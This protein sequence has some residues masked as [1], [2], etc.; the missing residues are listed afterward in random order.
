MKRKLLVF[1][2]AAV[3]G[4]L[5]VS[6]YSSGP[7]RAAT[8]NR[9]GSGST[10]AN[11]S[12]GGCHAG[13]SAATTVIIRVTNSSGANVTSWEPGA[14]YTVHIDGANT[15]G[16]S[17]FGF[18]S[19]AV[20]ATATGT[21]AGTFSATGDVGV[22]TG[23]TP[24]IIEHNRS[25]PGTVSGGAATY[26]AVYTWVAPAAGAGTVRFLA[27]LNAVNGDNST[28][29]D[30]PAA[31]TPLDLPEAS[32]TNVP[33]V[34][35]SQISVYPNPAGPSLHLRLPESFVTGAYTIRDVRGG[36]VRNGTLQAQ[37]GTAEIDV[38][39]LAGGAYFVQVRS[40]NAT[41]VAPFVKR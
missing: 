5:V 7:Y 2:I 37:Q 27:T 26:R 20:R 31:A 15:A 18:Q 12:G 3:L 28:S 29:G 1:P 36:I 8:L 40:G 41:L 6:S 19:T 39:T 9:T 33:G 24:N 23:A 14:T 32:G 34:A 21:Q 16:L 10:A 22:R 35:S 25:I 13:N 38:N 30:A 4:A 17:N 11:C